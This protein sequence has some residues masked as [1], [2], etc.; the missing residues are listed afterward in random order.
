M[1]SLILLLEGSERYVY[2]LGKA[3]LMVGREGPS[4]IQ[5]SSQSISS[6]HAS[7]VLEDDQLV[8][9]DNGSDNGSYVNGE[10]ITHQALRHHDLVRFGE[11]LFLVDLEDDSLTRNPSADARPNNQ[12][13]I[14][15]KSSKFLAMADIDPTNPP[16]NVEGKALKRSQNM[17]LITTD[18]FT[19][20]GQ[21]G[22]AH[23]HSV[24]AS[25]ILILEG[26]PR[27]VYLLGKENLMIGRDTA[28]HVS[29]PSESI[30]SDHASIVW[31]AGDFILDDKD[32]TNGSS[33]NGQSVRRQVLKHHDL[34]RFGEYLFLVS[35]KAA[36]IP[37]TQTFSTQAKEEET[38][39]RQAE[40]KITT[41]MDIAPPPKSKI[42]IQA[43]LPRRRPSAIRLMLTQ[44]VVK[45]KQAV[46]LRKAQESAGAQSPAASPQYAIKLSSFFLWVG[47]SV[48]LTIYGIFRFMPFDARD[49]IAM[50]DGFNRSPLRSL[51]K[52]AV[53]RD[54]ASMANRIQL[55]K[56]SRFSTQFAVPKMAR[57]MGILKLE[58]KPAAALHVT[59]TITP[60]RTD[61][62]SELTRTVKI[63]PVDGSIELFSEKLK[64]GSYSLECFCEDANPADEISAVLTLTSYH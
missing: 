37:E 22:G 4:D 3:T 39:S 33:V 13:P 12:Q 50:T 45:P 25:L 32:S 27:Y 59:A 18:S 60:T 9:R 34:V 15:D 6:N 23:S 17:R 35:I 54:N 14:K 43:P 55:T 8:L 30:S 16:Q 36:A 29:L 38:P 62:S 57:V 52:F 26:A 1:A 31:E 21:G 11:Y 48:L 41:V 49:A 61:A 51:L 19:L 46:V 63:N 64:P 58:Q 44:P 40:K 5:L 47:G 56:A 42:L 24:A 20:D 2:L 7:V 28:A 53:V 10:P